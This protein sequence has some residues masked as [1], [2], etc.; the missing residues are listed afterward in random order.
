MDPRFQ[1]R[2]HEVRSGSEDPHYLKNP[3]RVTD[4]EFEDYSDVEESDEENETLEDE[5]AAPTLDDSTDAILLHGILEVT[6]H[7]A[8]NIP[9]MDK[10][11]YHVDRCFFL[12]TQ[13]CSSRPHHPIGTRNDPY[14]AI[15]LGL[16]RVARTRVVHNKRHPV[17][18]E[19][20]RIPVAHHCSSLSFTL[21][22]DDAVGAKLIGKAIVPAATLC[23]DTPVSAWFDVATSGR[24]QPAHPAQIRLSLR[25]AP[26]AQ[27]PAYGA[28]WGRDSRVEDAYFPLRRGCRVTLYHDSHVSSSFAVR[29]ALEGGRTY[30]EGY[31]WEDICRTIL[32]AREVIYIGGWS[33]STKIA[34]MRDATRPMPEHGDMPLGE[35]LVKKAKQGVRVLVLIW[36][37]RT[38]LN[39]AAFRTAGMMGTL[40]EETYSYFR[41]TKV[42]C[43][44]MPRIPDKRLSWARKQTTF[45]TPHSTH[46][47]KLPSHTPSLF[48]P[49]FPSPPLPAS[50][51]PSPPLPSPPL[52][53]PPLSSPPFPAP[54]LSSPLLP[55]PPLPSPPRSSP[56]LP[57]PPVPLHSSWRAYLSVGRYDTQEHPLFRT[58]HAEHQG[59]FYQHNVKHQGDFYQHNVKTKPDVGPRQPWHDI[60]CKVEGSI[61]WDLLTN[62]EQRW[63]RATKGARASPRKRL[64]RGDIRALHGSAAVLHKRGYRMGRR[65]VVDREEGRGYWSK[66]VVAKRGERG[67][68]GREEG[69]GSER[70]ESLVGDKGVTVDRSIQDAYIAAIR[71]AHHFIHIENQYFLGSAYAWASHQGSG[72]WHSIPMEI[73]L[74][75]ARKIKSGERFSA[76]VVVPMW[77]E[78]DPKGAATQEILS[79]QS[80]TMEAMYRVIARALDEVQV[81]AEARAREA[82]RG[83]EA[84][85]IG[86]AGEW[87]GQGMAEVNAGGKGGEVGQKGWGGK[88]K[89]TV[90]GLVGQLEPEAEVAS[91]P[92]AAEAAAGEDAGAGGAASAHSPHPCDYLS[93][94]CLANRELPPGDADTT[95]APAPAADD[96]DNTGGNRTEGGKRN[97]NG[98]QPASPRASEQHHMPGLPGDSVL[99]SVLQHR[100]A[101]IYVHS[102]MMVVDDEYVVVGSA[103]INQ[104]SMDGARDTEM[105]VGAY[106][107]HHTW[108]ERGHA[109]KGQVHGFRMGLWAEHLG[110]LSPIHDHPWTLDCMRAVN[111][112]AQDR[113]MQ[114][115]GEAP[116][117]LQGHLVKYPIQVG[118]D[119]SVRPLPG[120]DLNP[121]HES[122]L[123]FVMAASRPALS[124]LL[125]FSRRILATSPAAPILP[126]GTL[127]GARWLQTGSAPSHAAGSAPGSGGATPPSEEGGET[128]DDFKPQIKAAEGVLPVYAQIKEDIKSC[129]VV[130]FMKGLPSAPMCGFSA[131]VVRVLAAHGVD[132]KGVNVLE[133]PDLREGIK[134]FSE[135]PTIP[136][137]YVNG[138]FIGGCDIVM[139]M[140]QSGELADL[141]KSLH[142]YQASSW[143]G[144]SKS[145]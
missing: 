119:G 97:S 94:F 140:H 19:T 27:D 1:A 9:T 66:R 112:S 124:P 75:I 121:F 40:D 4:E 123:L 76:Y 44:K 68:V 49:P 12:C 136:Q 69:R 132:F 96:G 92:A 143:L 105:A 62:F 6:V 23:G 129:P 43:F 103:N 86:E 60:Q 63:L 41:H 25:L 78:G 31:C 81:Q 28:G 71:R 138:E 56:L 26:V 30:E 95:A 84:T 114:W 72:A 131:A 111:Q 88:F 20:F 117:E 70:E 54:P 73:A 106:Q 144:R 115:A 126:L 14:V 101:M 77:P 55:S 22:D 135:W 65:S 10:I 64:H 17:W 107:P 80:R 134:S 51:L 99:R 82:E 42:V 2:V 79:W 142:S 53:S 33:V 83:Q 35:L 8:R 102:K 127:I 59:D 34:L 15:Y 141:L 46:H 61:V 39:N 120:P 50:P 52:P 32:D 108:R 87:E 85:V 133:D 90:K 128:H 91:R 13:P 37:D 38:S 98:N 145:L 58:L 118:R 116:V 130:V 24:A 100:R 67:E 3:K 57:S 16:A 11:A 113:W 48:S 36:D 47:Q 29:A 137:V 122:R 104:R 109:P 45:P 21:K 89:E 110:S 5:D 125:A 7:E 18:E 93:F 139:K 74:K